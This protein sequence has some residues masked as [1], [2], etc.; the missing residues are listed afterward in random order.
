MIEAL[1]RA[2]DAGLP[3]DYA[4]GN[5]DYAVETYRGPFDRVASE[6]LAQPG[7]A[8]A[9]L[10]EHGDLVNDDDRQYRRWRTFSRSR[11]IL[12][13]YLA[14]PGAVGLPLSQWLERRMRT[15]NLAYKRRFPAEHVGRRA[16]RLLGETGARWLVLGHFHQEL[17]QAVQG[18][19][20]LVLPDW[21]RSRR[22]L[23]WDPVAGT[24]EFKDSEPPK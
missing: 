16:G 7:G 1:G 13:A 8:P 5:R 2:R 24:M 21:K 15:S 20:A 14:L 3:V 4:V 19:E 10:A 6:T 23:E 12:G 22:H 17:R 11:P 9:W 18:G